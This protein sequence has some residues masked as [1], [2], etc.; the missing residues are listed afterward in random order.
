MTSLN[1]DRYRYKPDFKRP[2]SKLDTLEGRSNKTID[3]SLENKQLTKEMMN[4]SI[5]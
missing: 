5:R 2:M 3:V 1:N 4:K